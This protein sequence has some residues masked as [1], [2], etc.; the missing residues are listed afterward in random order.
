[1]I[2]WNPW[3]IELRIMK[4]KKISKFYMITFAV[5]AIA[6]AGCSQSAQKSKADI[7]SVHTQNANAGDR[8]AHTDGMD[9]STITPK[10]EGI[11]YELTTSEFKKKIM[12]YEKHPQEW[13]FEGKRPVIIDF[14]A[15]WC[16][17]C[18][19]TAP[20]VEEL[21]KD[22][23][24]KIDFYKVDID[25]EQELAATFG[26]QSIPTFLFI[27]AKGTPTMQTGA[28]EKSDF[29]KII[30]SVIFK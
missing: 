24:G 6:M 4:M 11:V 7:A 1:M 21:A 27:P 13:V 29:E 22:Y 28:M 15:T 14:Y 20:V 23:Q 25:K 8:K 30:K 18:K 19:M 16:R 5:A 3:Q 2:I 10:G 12:N 26:I 17:P 9:V